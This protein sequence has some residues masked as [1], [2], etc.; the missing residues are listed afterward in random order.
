MADLIRHVA[1]LQSSIPEPVSTRPRS[2]RPRDPRDL[3]HYLLNE[4]WPARD[5]ANL[6]RIQ[7]GV[8]H[9]LLIQLIRAFENPREPT[10]ANRAY[11]WI[12]KLGLEAGKRNEAA[13]VP[14]LMEIALP[15][16]TTSVEAWQIGLIGGGLLRGLQ[17]SG[18]NASPRLQSILQRDSVL[19]ERWIRWTSILRNQTHLTDESPDQLVSDA[20]RAMQAAGQA[21]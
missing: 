14:R 6:L 2:T 13:P 10:E 9:D 20:Q 19:H 18:L 17:E 3:A 15:V 4:Q 1:E 11:Q 12:R 16:D 7:Y 21:P 8:E 5:R